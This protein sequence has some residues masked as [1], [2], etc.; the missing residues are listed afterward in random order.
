MNNDLRDILN[1]IN[2]ALN[3]MMARIAR[4]ELYALLD[5]P[6]LRMLHLEKEAAEKE[7]VLDDIEKDALHRM[8]ELKHHTT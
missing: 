4:L 3:Q 1:L 2:D 6:Q 5:K 8:D 7:S